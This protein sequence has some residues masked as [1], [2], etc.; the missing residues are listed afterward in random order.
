MGGGSREIANFF[1]ISSGAKMSKRCPFP[2]LL[3]TFPM[4]FWCTPHKN[5]QNFQFDLFSKKNQGFLAKFGLISGL[6][7]VHK[8]ENFP[9]PPQ[10]LGRRGGPTPPCWESEPGG[11]TLFKTSLLSLPP[12]KIV[13]VWFLILSSFNE[14]PNPCFQQRTRKQTRG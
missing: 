14:A 3:S 11:L 10:F 8:V 7:P 4:I 5:M 1:Q 6:L 12:P 2:S 13:F 9:S